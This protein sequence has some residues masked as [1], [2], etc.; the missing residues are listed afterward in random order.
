MKTILFFVLSLAIVGFLVYSPHHSRVLYIFA[1][2]PNELDR[3]VMRD[4]MHKVPGQY[5]EVSPD[6]RSVT[7]DDLHRE[8]EALDKLFVWVDTLPDWETRSCYRGWLAYYQND[9]NGTW[10]A[11]RAERSRLEYERTHALPEGPAQ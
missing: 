6:F 1:Y 2:C 7:E 10:S 8:Q 9:L 3:M 5:N 4:V 11:V